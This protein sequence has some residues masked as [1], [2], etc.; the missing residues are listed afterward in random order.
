M[1]Q[2]L[3]AI[4]EAID[5]LNF[6]LLN[7]MITRIDWVSMLIERINAL[8]NNQSPQ[9]SS[10]NRDNAQDFDD[11]FLYAVSEEVDVV[12]TQEERL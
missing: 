3:K 10:I 7:H 6:G 12:V 9:R 2:M 1:D 5:K 8:Q 4:N 11:V